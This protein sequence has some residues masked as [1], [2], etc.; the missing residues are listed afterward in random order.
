MSFFSDLLGIGGT[1]A[2]FIPGGQ[3]IGA[4]LSAAGGLLSAGEQQ[5]SARRARRRA[6]R[7]EDRQIALQED[8]YNWLRDLSE[9][10]RGFVDESVARGDFDPQRVMAS[11]EG[12][13]AEYDQ[14]NLSNIAG[15]HRTLGYKEGDSGPLKTLAAAT[16]QS[17]RALSKVRMELPRRLLMEK[18]AAYAATNPQLAQ[19]AS[20]LLS[21]ALGNRADS[22]YRQG[23]IADANT[24]NPAGFLKVLDPFL[25]RT[26]NPAGVG[27]PP[28]SGSFLQRPVLG[29]GMVEPDYGWLPK[30]T[31]QYA[32]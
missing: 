10:L 28:I 14:R 7:V 5:S 1:V 9:M 3:A 24:P 4:G 13:Q 26:Q 16:S 23:D 11:I 25:N 8:Q 32:S 29:S 19:G 17:Q 15:A 20:G 2:S 30:R 21:N 31:L 6:G 27:T 12:Q 22:L 18:L